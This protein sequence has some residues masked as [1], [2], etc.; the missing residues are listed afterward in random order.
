MNFPAQPVK[1][2][3]QPQLVPDDVLEITLKIGFVHSAEHGQALIEVRGQPSGDLL[4]MFS[5]HHFPLSETEARI[6]EVGRELTRI[7]RERSGPFS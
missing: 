2:W 6:R 5:M 1:A 3:T 4:E 7:V